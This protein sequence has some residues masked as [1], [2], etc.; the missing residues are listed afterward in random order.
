[1]FLSR[2]IVFLAGAVWVSGVS[3]PRDDLKADKLN[4]EALAVLQNQESN[5]LAERETNFHNQRCTLQN[6]VRRRDW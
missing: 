5:K 3:L 1:M 4:A 2:L 6:A